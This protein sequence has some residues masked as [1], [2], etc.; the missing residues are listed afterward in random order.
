M[1]VGV[2]RITL[3]C[4]CRLA[5][6][7]A[8]APQPVPYPHDLAASAA[9]ASGHRVRPRGDVA[10]SDLPARLADVLRN[11]WHVEPRTR[12]STEYPV[13]SARSDKRLTN[14]LLDAL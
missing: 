2:P 9:G 6:G 11:P 5:A 13:K 14:R 1:L 10:P 3:E 7:R 8:S 12:F 4:A